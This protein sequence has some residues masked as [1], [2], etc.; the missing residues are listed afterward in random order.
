MKLSEVITFFEDF[1]DNFDSKKA[2]KLLKDLDLDIDEKLSKM[3][4]GM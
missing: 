2:K 1:Y 3:S 4:K